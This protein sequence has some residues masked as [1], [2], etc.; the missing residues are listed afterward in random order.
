MAVAVPPG[1]EVLFG[2]HACELALLAGY[3]RLHRACV[4][5]GGENSNA[6]EIRALAME[7]DIPVD[8]LSKW[9]MNELCDQ[10]PH[11][12]CAL[13][14]EPVE[15]GVVNAVEL[16]NACLSNRSQADASVPPL[17]ICLDQVAD[18]RNLGAIL[19]TAQFL[20][21]DAVVVST[22]NSAPLSPVVSK[23]SA[24][25]LETLLQEGRLHSAR[26]MPLFLDGCRDAGWTV[27]GADAGE[28]A[29]PARALALSG[30]PVVVVMGNEGSG[31]RTMVR[32]SCD[33]LVSIGA[34]PLRALAMPGTVSWQVDSLN[35]SVAAGILVDQIA[36][37]MEQPPSQQ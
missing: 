11:Q 14:T 31:L 4:V 28:A 22:K 10:Q 9:D 1:L 5:E 12:G 3:R 29:Q 15:V 26:Q 24:G 25:A 21:C 19:R 23:A 13:L 20:R 6:Q 34:A 2:R 27:L 18:P 37:C 33:S 30:K 32:R 35:V 36:Q 7:R 17:V 16:H 8:V